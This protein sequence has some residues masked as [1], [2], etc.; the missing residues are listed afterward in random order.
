MLAG[1]SQR[2]QTHSCCSGSLGDPRLC[3]NHRR[4]QSHKTGNTV[5]LGKTPEVNWTQPRGICI[6]YK[7]SQDCSFASSSI[8][9][10]L[11]N[12]RHTSDSPDKRK[13]QDCSA[14]CFGGD[15]NST[16]NC[17]NPQN[18]R[19]THHSTIHHDKQEHSTY[20]LKSFP[21]TQIGLTGRMPLASRA[22]SIGRHILERFEY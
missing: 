2:K 20:H 17:M 12:Y 9:L 13:V 21:R 11:K 5:D 18:R 19:N 1:N 7:C 3:D 10:T 6:H 22:T 16:S 15:T 8:L 4:R 14:P